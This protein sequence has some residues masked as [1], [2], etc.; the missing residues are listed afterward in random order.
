MRT[1]A[2][3]P[4]TS[5][6]GPLETPRIRC[7]T[8]ASGVCQSSRASDLGD[9]RDGPQSSRS[10]DRRAR[11]PRRARAHRAKVARRDRR[12]RCA[13]RSTASGVVD[14]LRPRC[15]PSSSTTLLHRQRIREA[16]GLDAG[17]RLDRVDDRSAAVAKRPAR[18]GTSCGG[19]ATRN[20]CSDS[21]AVKPGSTSRSASNVRIMRP[22]LTSRTSASAT[23]PRRARSARDAARARRSRRASRRK[24]VASRARAARRTGA[25]AEQH[26]GGQR[27][28]AAPKPSERESSAIASRRGKRCGANAIKPATRRRRATKP[29]RRRAT[30][31]N[32][33]SASS[34]RAMR[35]EP[36]PS[37]ARTSS[38]GGATLAA[39]EQQVRDVRARDQQ[40]DRRSSP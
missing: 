14:G 33:L 22:E 37:A 32:A 35:H 29:A 19:T 39:H 2:T 30:A 40:H 25:D 16:R 38:S 20:V 31:S 1:S 15:R 13:A 27:D 24:R 11:D 28:T 36:A 34:E 4:I 18:R 26:R 5:R 17:N 21:A 12:C 3:T 9:E 7:P 6:Q 10:S 23:W 8:A